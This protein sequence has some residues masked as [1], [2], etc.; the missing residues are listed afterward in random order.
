MGEVSRQL[1]LREMSGAIRE[2]EARAARL[3]ECG[4]AYATS[5]SRASFEGQAM[6]LRDAAGLM[7]DAYARVKAGWPEG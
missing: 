5:C 4:R 7:R 1:V 6:G 3:E 2:A